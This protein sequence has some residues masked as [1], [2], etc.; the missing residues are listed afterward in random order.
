[1]VFTMAAYIGSSQRRLALEISSAQ[2]EVQKCLGPILEL[3]PN[4]LYAKVRSQYCSP[5]RL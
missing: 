1:V 5:S 4:L 3:P 2:V